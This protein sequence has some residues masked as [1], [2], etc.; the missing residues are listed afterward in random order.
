MQA[1]G[2]TIQ[3]ARVRQ[4]ASNR[5]VSLAGKEVNEDGLALLEEVI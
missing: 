2:R 1:F 3:G 5:G 4:R